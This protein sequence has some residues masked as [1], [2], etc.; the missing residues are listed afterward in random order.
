LIFVIE[1]SITKLVYNIDKGESVKDE[2]IFLSL[3]T[4]F[5]GSLFLDNLIFLLFYQLWDYSTVIIYI[6]Q[7]DL[8]KRSSS[9]LLCMQVFILDLAM[10]QKKKIDSP[11]HN[12]R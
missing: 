12:N 6:P 10:V 9:C 2:Y 11:I 5:R 8:N 7:E 3:F 4:V 1:D